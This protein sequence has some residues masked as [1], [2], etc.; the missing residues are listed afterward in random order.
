MVHRKDFFL[1]VLF[2]TLVL[3][4]TLDKRFSTHVS[5]D[6]T[7]HLQYQTIQE[8]INAA[9]SGDVIHIVAGFYQESIVVNKTLRIL[10]DDKQTTIIQANATDVVRIVADNVYISGFTIR[11]GDLGIQVG[12]SNCTITDNIV[13]NNSIGIRLD[14]SSNCVVSDNILVNNTR[15]AIGSGIF[16]LERSTENIL[17]NNR[18]ENSGE[19]IYLLNSDNN[20]VMRNLL[21]NNSKTGVCLMK[22]TVSCDNNT[23]RDNIIKWGD[24]FGID[25]YSVKHNVIVNNTVAN[26][27]VNL[28][29]DHAN[30]NT[31][32]HNNFIKSPKVYRQVYSVQSQN[33]WDNGFE[34]NYWSDDNWT[35]Y[36]LYGILTKPYNI[37]LSNPIN[38]DVYPLRSCY[39]MGDANHDGIINT[40]DAELLKS[41]WQLVQSEVGYSPYVDFNQDMIVNIIDATIIG[42]NW[43]KHV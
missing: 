21:E 29:I 26:T 25:L 43:L 15:N 8:T 3:G 16:L 20:I 41:S 13:F 31:F 30:N 37:S 27:G 10:G 6:Y 1:C 7:S 39:L 9:N 28:F 18:I 34:G 4:L 11:N 33:V 32:Y 23:I 12:A 17:V 38:K 5:P 2:F 36:N 19:G 22:G 40:A 14:S 42:T 35:D 24:T